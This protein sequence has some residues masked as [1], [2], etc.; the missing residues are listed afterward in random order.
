MP[1]T[2][3]Y[4]SVFISTLLVFIT[5]CSSTSEKPAETQAADSSFPDQLTETSWEVASI[6]GNPA[7]KGVATLSFAEQDR[8]GGTTGCNNFSGQVTREGTTL[9]FGMLATTR[10]MCEPALNG[11]ERAY[12]EALDTVRG[13]RR[14]GGQL[15]LIDDE[16]QV[17]ISLQEAGS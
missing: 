6:Y 11:Q 15:E 2:T 5:A 17:V 7:D 4:R 9:D 1:G 3:L 8:V 13:W 12:L 14:T 16:G 10:K